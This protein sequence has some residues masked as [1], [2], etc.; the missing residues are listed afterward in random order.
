MKN[1]ILIGISLV[2]VILSISCS[3]HPQVVAYEGEVSIIPEPAELAVGKEALVLDASTKIYVP[4]GNEQVQK[5]AQ[6]F[7]DQFAQASGIQLL[8]EAKDAATD[9]IVL[10]IADLDLPA[11]GYLLD[12]TK[13]GIKIQASEASG[14]FYGLQTLKQL[15]PAA[16]E[17]STLVQNVQWIV[18]FATIKDY[19]QYSWR[20]L[21]LDVS[22]H[23]SSLD[24]V[25]KYLDYMAMHKLNTF[26]WHLTDDQG[27]RIEI[28]KYPLLTEIGAWREGTLIG[29]AGS[30]EFDTIRYGG[31]YTQEEIKEVV[32]YA[33]DRF[34]TVVPEIE[35]PGHATAA[36]AAY[37]ELGVT[38]NR[39]KVVKEWGVFLDIY[40]IEDDT[41][42][43]LE[44]VIDEVV[45]LFPGEYIHI[46]GD[47]AWKDQWKS[48]AVVQAKIKELGL[49]DEHELQSWFIE[50]MEKYI[51]SKGKQIIGWDEILEGGLAPNAAVMSWR[52]EEGGIAAAKQHHKVVMTP[53]GYMYFDHFQGDPKFEPLQI[54]GYNT[55]EN[56]YSY[57][58][59]PDALV[60]EERDY[61]MG[62]QANVW[63]EYLPNPEKIE[64]VVFPRLAALSEVVWTPLERKSWD[65][66]K[67]KIP[68]ELERYDYK[69]INYAKSIFYVTYD[70]K[71]LE[72]A[73][74][75]EVSLKNQWGIA[76]M[77]F[78]LDG[79]EP[80]ASS[81]KYSEPLQLAEGTV[82]KAVVIENGQ[83]KAKV[84]EI[85]VTKPE[86]KA[87][88]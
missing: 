56:V 51:N 71:A 83:P 1:Q 2:L 52:G 81:Q 53:G 68:T 3:Q 74:L 20:G 85:T 21:H 47:E 76:D 33:A 11:E 31:F 25:K 29:H 54:H 4:A 38:G 35:M 36:V 65:K 50:R 44:D 80:T 30:V 43:F 19:P 13:T 60:G 77:Y 72:N 12:V 45:A 79:S 39:P 55:L 26:H 40:G 61:I 63:T 15:L 67:S 49:K 16:I 9:G 69:N 10:Q 88:H 46:G 75:L 73:E 27:W 42:E 37:P 17:S 5:L 70:V 82:I 23:M 64:Y 84:T 18:P 6:S 78:T 24:F 8:V 14:L 41:F 62:A 66:F 22:R 34:I 48:D 57:N 28:K 86:V 59:T 32:A 58:P 87:A 7:A